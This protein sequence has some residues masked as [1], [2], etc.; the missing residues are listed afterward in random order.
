M[1]RFIYG[2]D[3]DHPDACAKV[4]KQKGYDCVVASSSDQKVIG[5]VREAGLDYVLC[6]SAF[7]L[8][9][10]NPVCAI[11]CAGNPRVW[12]GSGCPNNE[13]LRK[14]RLEEYGHKASIPGINGVWIDGAR[15]ASFASSEGTDSFF[16]CFCPTC[17][18]K[19]EQA[20]FDSV[21]MR[22]AV[23]RF[24]RFTREGGNAEESLRGIA[25]W[26]KFRSLCVREFLSAFSDMVHA[27]GVQ[28]GAF[29]FAPSLA[30]WVGQGDVD[31]CG[32]DVISPML[33]RRYPAKDG[34]ACLNHEW[35]AL[36]RLMT[37]H[38]GLS[39]EEAERLVNAPEAMPK[40]VL[41]EG[42]SPT[43]IGKECTALHSRALLAPIL[44]LEDTELSR[45]VTAAYKGGA[46]AIGVF[47]YSDMES[48]PDLR[49][50]T[51]E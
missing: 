7:S 14:K 45:C 19:A 16:T 29:V 23:E 34:P 31:S 11:D 17:M 15:F 28:S 44:Q 30:R 42:F 8:D 4:L 24:S 38:T 46:E 13:E 32:L 41:S 35:E 21:K 9:R 49:I 22:S 37:E 26:L 33:Y 48:I 43:Q 3:R 2:I 40:R 5:S 10:S 1:K 27:R 39:R 6:V 36:M 25:D 51:E 12:F 18:R 20:G 50:E 47:A